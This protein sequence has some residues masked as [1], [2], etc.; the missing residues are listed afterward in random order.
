MLAKDGQQVLI[1][2]E[3]NCMKAARD[4]AIMQLSMREK[5]NN[6]QAKEIADPD[7]RLRQWP[8][9]TSA[10]PPLFKSSWGSEPSLSHEAG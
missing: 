8:M 1:A 9:S 3:G 10:H 2:R 4:D 5:M 6:R 7:L